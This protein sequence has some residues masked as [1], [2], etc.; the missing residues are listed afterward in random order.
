[1][2]VKVIPSAVAGTVQAPCSKSHTMRALVLAA[3]SSG[4]CVIRQPL[5]SQ[6]VEAMM[7]ALQRLGILCQRHLH[8]IVVQGNQ[9]RFDPRHPVLVDAKNSGQIFRFLT[10]L[11]PLS[12]KRVQVTGD[13]SILSQ[14]PII[15]LL[16]ALSDMG[17]ET[18]RFFPISVFGSIEK[19]HVSIE[20][21]DSQPV[22]ALMLLATQLKEALEITVLNPSEK[23]WLDFTLHWLQKCGVWFERKEH[24]YFKIYPKKIQ[25]FEVTIPGDYSQAAF[26]FALGALSKRPI[27]VTNLDPRDPQGDKIV[28]SLLQ[29]MGVSI[30]REQDRVT[31][32]KNKLEGIT[33]RMDECIDAVPIL[34]VLGCFANTPMTLTHI[35][36]ARFKES[37]R[38]AC[39]IQELQKMGAHIEADQE[40]V[41]IYPSELK[42]AKLQTHCDHRIAMALTVAAL[43]AKTP[44]VI[45]K[46]E[47]VS[48]SYPTFFEDLQTLGAQLCR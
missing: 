24:H 46:A 11:S 12:T 44:S 39:M 3:L 36:G 40:K 6:D 23:P 18:K 48:K 13:R 45:E 30:S 37:D 41:V 15:P 43:C 1:M 2:I 29:A 5:I 8:H 28:L 16:D 38:I 34:M 7:V 4:I 25:P 19:H 42:G 32:V 27:T 33:C 20:G 9:G 47:V 31:V 14:R 17:F 26:Y 21:L 10:A 35:E 22:S